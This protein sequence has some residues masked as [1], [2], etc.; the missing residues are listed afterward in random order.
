VADKGF[1]DLDCYKL[2]MEVFEEAYGVAAKL[3]AVERY[4][5]SD[6]MRRAA[7]SAI[8]NIAEGYGRYHYLDK[9]K[10]FYIARGSL[11]ETL[12]AFGACEAV[13]YLDESDL[14][15]QRTL[16]HRALQALNGFIRFTHNQ[17][18]GQ[19]EFGSRTL[20]ESPIEY[21]IVPYFQAES[22]DPESTNPESTN[23]GG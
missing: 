14:E 11:T 1:E 18:Q 7:T 5:L 21:H 6:Q 12:A 4:N 13:R 20:H 23:P 10:F 17:K 16:C 3:P 19:Q 15:R 2:A 9:V 8:L 22:T